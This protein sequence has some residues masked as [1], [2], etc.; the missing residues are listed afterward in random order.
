VVRVNDS[1]MNRFSV[2]REAGSG[3]RLALVH[4]RLLATNAN[5]EHEG[6]TLSARCAFPPANGPAKLLALSCAERD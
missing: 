1:S 5:Y 2:Y 4:G 6:K 3:T